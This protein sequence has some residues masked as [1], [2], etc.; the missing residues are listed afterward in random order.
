MICSDSRGYWVCYATQEIKKG[1]QIQI[2]YQKIPSY[3]MMIDYGFIDT[4]NDYEKIH[5]L[6][7][8]LTLDSDKLNLLDEFGFDDD[9]MFCDKNVGCS[10]ALQNAAIIAICSK[11]DIKNQ[12]F[13]DYIEGKLRVS[14]KRRESAEKLLRQVVNTRIE[15][16]KT[17]LKDGP[18][19]PLAEVLFRVQIEFLE[20]TLDK[21][22]KLYTL[23]QRYETRKD[24]RRKEQF[25]CRGSF[26]S[27]LPGFGE[28]RSRHY[29]DDE[30]ED[31]DE[32]D[33]NSQ[34]LLER[35]Y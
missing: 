1:E 32:N 27:E 12:I 11:C 22:A 3:N 8:D 29:S 30:E 6:P 24:I 10:W 20:E 18:N 15:H 9:T 17:Q 34:S 14:D 16:L 28:L 2:S 31:K 7:T 23:E 25:R 26:G 4:P 21:Y 5:F 19:H 13:Q 33:H 35:C